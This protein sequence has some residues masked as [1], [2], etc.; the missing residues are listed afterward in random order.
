MRNGFSFFPDEH[1]AAG[2]RMSGTYRLVARF[3]VGATVRSPARKDPQID[4]AV[5]SVAEVRQQV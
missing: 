3:Q 5:A 4:G 1:D 2:T